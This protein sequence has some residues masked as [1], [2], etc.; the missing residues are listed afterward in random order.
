MNKELVNTIQ[1]RTWKNANYIKNIDT[2]N[3]DE[4]RAWRESL[5]LSLEQV[6]R[7]VGLTKSMVAKI[8]RG[9]RGIT[10]ETALKFLKVINMI[11]LIK[12]DRTGEKFTLVPTSMM[13]DI[14]YWNHEYKRLLTANDELNRKL[15]KANCENK[16]LKA[17]VRRLESTPEYQTEQAFRN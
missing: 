3:G 16:D 8:E 4:L 9:E 13:N 1:A 6:A 15:Y 5:N 11:M 17:R 10:T 12:P 14:A 7:A 2:L